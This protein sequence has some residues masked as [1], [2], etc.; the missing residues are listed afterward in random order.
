[1]KSIQTKEVLIN[2]KGEDLK[3]ENN[4][5][6][7]IGEAL[8]NIVLSNKEGGKLK[9]FSLAQRLFTEPFVEVDDADF[10]L[11]EDAVLNTEIYGVIVSGQLL[12]ILGGIK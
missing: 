2:F 12:S 4:A 6:L 11:I 7:T 9:C 8:S 3:T 5:S 10:K 1:M